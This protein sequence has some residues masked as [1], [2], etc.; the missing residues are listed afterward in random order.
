M[1]HELSDSS[2]FLAKN[3]SNTEGILKWFYSYSILRLHLGHCVI[4][5]ILARVV[6]MFYKWG[7][8]MLIKIKATLR[9]QL[10]S[11]VGSYAWD[12]MQHVFLWPSW[13]QTHLVDL[14]LTVLYNGNILLIRL[15][16]FLLTLQKKELLL[17]NDP[18]FVH[19]VVSISFSLLLF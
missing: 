5:H 10:I 16:F 13:T 18:H 9:V 11:N 14:H 3:P 1:K 15:F 19:S 4:L 6:T 7:S 2:A 12:K 17:G 8:K